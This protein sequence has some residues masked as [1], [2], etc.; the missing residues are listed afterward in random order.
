MINACKPKNVVLRYKI[1]SKCVEGDSCL[2]KPTGI[3]RHRLRALF[4]GGDEGNTLEQTDWMRN[5]RMYHSGE[6]F[7]NRNYFSIAEPE[8]ENITNLIEGWEWEWISVG[9]YGLHTLRAWVGKDTDHECFVVLFFSMR[10]VPRN[11]KNTLFRPGIQR[12]IL[13]AFFCFF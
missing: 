9:L 2:Q 5:T 3:R 12:R 8:S 13:R 1:M 4:G 10:V 11:N 6:K 7:L